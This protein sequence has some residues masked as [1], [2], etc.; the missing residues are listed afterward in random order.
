MSGPA[1]GLQEL[2]VPGSR[3]NDEK[4]LKDR[5]SGSKVSNNSQNVV[6]AE[7]TMETEPLKRQ[8]RSTQCVETSVKNYLSMHMH[9]HAPP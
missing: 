6:D 4:L 1:W 9:K 8:P 3:T 2:E 7:P 5:D